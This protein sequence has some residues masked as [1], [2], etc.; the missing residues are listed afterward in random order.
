MPSLRVAGKIHTT[1]RS[2]CS[3]VLYSMGPK[4]CCEETGLVLIFLTDNMALVLLKKNGLRDIKCR[5]MICSFCLYTQSHFQR[6]IEL[7]RKTYKT[8]QPQAIWKSVSGMNY[9]FLKNI[10][11]ISNDSIKKVKRWGPQWRKWFWN[12]YLRQD[13]YLEHI[14]RR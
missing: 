9:D 2:Q 5:T 8:R 10:I 6:S 12:I 1:V 14:I 3:E 13:L 4:G 7:L 11:N